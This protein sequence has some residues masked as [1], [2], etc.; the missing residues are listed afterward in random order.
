MQKKLAISYVRFSTVE[1]L[2]GDSLRRQTEATEA[3]CKKHGLTLTDDYRLR[4]LGKSAYKGVHRNATG[5]L[6]QFEKQVAAG[7]IP[8][9]TV[10][11][12]ENL[13][14]LSRED[15]VTA[16]LLLLNLIN[17]G[18]EIVALS[19]NE[20][21]Y[22]KES[23]AANPFELIISIMV[24]SRAHEESK[25]KSYRG[26]ESWINRNRLAA[27]GKHIKMRLPSWLE[28]KNQKY[29]VAPE[30]AAVI[31]KIFR[32]YLEGF[33]TQSIAQML[34]KEGVPNIANSKAEKKTWHPTYIQRILKSK[35]VIGY[36]T[37]I[38]PDVPN[39]FPAIVTESDFYAVQATIKKRQTYK[40]QK[41]NNPH[42]LS[43]LLKCDLCGL[44]V[45]RCLGNGYKYFQCFGATLKTCK[46]TT[47]SIYGTEVALL[48]VIAAATPGRGGV[49]DQST[50]DTQRELE[51]IQGKIDELD[52][53]IVTASELFIDNPSEAGANILKR[54]ETD[55]I[56]YK[57]QLEDK[58][59]TKFLHDHRSDWKDVKAR[60]EAA[61]ID[62]GEYP[63]DVI[64]VSVMIV[65]G[66]L[67]YLR[68][69][70]ANDEH[71][72][73]NLRE[74]LRGYIEKI[75]IN[76]P[77]MEATIYFKS[78]DKMGVEFRKSKSYPRTYSYKTNDGDWVDLGKDP[79][80]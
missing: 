2:G 16:Q 11:I 52:S 76:I 65:D 73:I 44:S 39:Y 59:N 7:R 20:R 30:K 26:K 38:N 41:N 66:K 72:I 49:D 9:G 37:G 40:G 12:V 67:E 50:R 21:R 29:I 10:L 18:I 6:G 69:T 8:K 58:R 17:H 31:K 55:K 56:K 75:C 42:P 64:P 1:Q 34:I 3:Y 36:Y 25:I 27:E 78:G 48:K 22:S 62:A 46:P 77:K 43:H 28:S 57:K 63:L 14:R 61:I 13:D 51:A 35:E 33:G 79:L 4:D 70:A 74:T 23:L 80:Q 5:A 45:V 68:H 71:G 60:L 24:M 32:L 15:I 47:L 19:D 54:L 53:K